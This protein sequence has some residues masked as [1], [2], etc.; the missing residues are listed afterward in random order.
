[1]PREDLAVRS[2]KKTPTNKKQIKQQDYL[3]HN[4]NLGFDSALNQS[5]K[6][7]DGKDS[8][9]LDIGIGGLYIK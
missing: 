2:G 8:E 3:N 4:R 5:L 6:D 7:E 9:N 1:M